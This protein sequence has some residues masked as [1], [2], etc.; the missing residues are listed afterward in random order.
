MPDGNLPTPGGWNRF[1]IE[2]A[3]LVATVDRVRAAGVP[4]SPRRSTW[5]TRWP[6]GE[7]ASGRCRGRDGP[8]GL[9]AGAP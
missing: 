6:S 3:D 9:G 7:R 2:V 1:S 8:G 4:C 5:P